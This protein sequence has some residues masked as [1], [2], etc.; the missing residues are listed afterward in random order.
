MSEGVAR[1]RKSLTALGAGLLTIGLAFAA[2]PAAE[3]QEPKY[4]GTLIAAFAADPGG[5]DPARGPSG[6]SHVVIEQV[7]STLLRLDHNAKPYPGL[8][9]SWSVSEDGLTW[10][11]QLRE[12]LKFHNGEDLTAEDMFTNQFIDESIGF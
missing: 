12:G 1:E 6:M 2:V 3:A 5:F 4:G 7:F 8:A 11:F 9:H 10:T